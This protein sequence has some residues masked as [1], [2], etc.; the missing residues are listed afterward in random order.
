VRS[1]PVAR[2]L[3]SLKLGLTTAAPRI[4]GDVE[5]QVGG[6]E[7]SGNRESPEEVHT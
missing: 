6:L 7:I 3:L 2:N 1:W 5:M 4:L